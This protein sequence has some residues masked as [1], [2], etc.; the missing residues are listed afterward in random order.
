MKQ[1]DAFVR[2]EEAELEM[3]TRPPA[4]GLVVRRSWQK[5][6]LTFLMVIGHASSG[7]SARACHPENH[8]TRASS[9]L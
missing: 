9:F 6:L 7:N 5:D 8:S 1:V 3:T 4:H 2:I